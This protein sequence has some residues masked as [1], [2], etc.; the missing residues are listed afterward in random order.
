MSSILHIFKIESGYH[1]MKA[2]CLTYEAVCFYFFKWRNLH[3][4]SKKN[5]SV[6]AM[7]FSI[8]KACVRLPV[9]FIFYYS[10]LPLHPVT[11]GGRRGG[12]NDRAAYGLEC[13][14][15][16]TKLGNTILKLWQFYSEWH[17]FSNRRFKISNSSCTTSVLLVFM[18][19]NI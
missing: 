8:T 10:D 13:F 1:I 6:M 3:F 11:E 5:L 9:I 18:K 7:V 15:R 12:G 17:G 2:H 19:I 4:P 16:K 14:C